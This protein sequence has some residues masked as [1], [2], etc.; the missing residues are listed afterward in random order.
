MADVEEDT[1]LGAPAA[2]VVSAGGCGD[3]RSSVER[4]MAIDYVQVRSVYGLRVCDREGMREALGQF[5]GRR[6]VVRRW[7]IGFSVV[8]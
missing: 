2:S 6:W 7:R 3:P 4:G 5:V 1:S 8:A